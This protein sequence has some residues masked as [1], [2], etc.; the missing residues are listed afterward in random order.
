MD[1]AGFPSWVR[2]KASTP[3]GGIDAAGF[4]S[5]VR[6]KASIPRGGTDAAGKYFACFIRTQRAFK[7]S[8]S[9]F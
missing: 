5:W 8:Y 9:S 6:H 2:H 7:S 4:P 3:R 1:A